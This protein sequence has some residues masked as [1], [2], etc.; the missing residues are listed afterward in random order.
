M[1]RPD[2]PAEVDALLDLHAAG[3][4]PLHREDYR[5]SFFAAL[6]PAEVEADLRAAN[7]DDLELSLVADRYWL[8]SGRTRAQTLARPSDPRT[9]RM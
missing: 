2:T 7:L 5:N 6:T 3:A 1:R 4:D 8:V 9:S